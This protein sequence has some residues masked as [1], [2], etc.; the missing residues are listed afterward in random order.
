MLTRPCLCAF[1]APHQTLSRALQR[2]YF[3]TWADVTYEEA[4]VEVAAEH[5]A[6]RGCSLAI[7]K[8]RRAGIMARARKADARRIRA[9]ARAGLAVWR[10][11]S[12]EAR[13]LREGEAELVARLAVVRA[14][15]GIARWRRWTASRMQSSV[16]TQIAAMH[17][18]QSRMRWGL[19]RLHTATRAAALERQ[20]AARTAKA[21][22]KTLVLRR[23]LRAWLKHT[24]LQSKV[25]CW[26]R[27]RTHR[28][29]HPL[30]CIQVSD[31]RAFLCVCTFG[32]S[33]MPS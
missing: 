14:K 29:C 13:D 4:Q 12:R 27:P 5:Y 7:R 25:R 21:A 11:W 1:P 22:H 28:P 30:P 26:S 18:Q 3:R 2:N 32:A 31:A 33:G 10:V 19:R 20:M 17:W 16:A 23:C 15:Q 9:R 6:R 24:A 8:L